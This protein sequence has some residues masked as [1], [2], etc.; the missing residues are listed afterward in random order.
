MDL[1][2][3]AEAV[4]EGRQEEAVRARRPEEPQAA[5][6]ERTGLPRIPGC[7]AW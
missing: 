5:E 7:Q 6:A 1:A 4:A 3:V 2:G